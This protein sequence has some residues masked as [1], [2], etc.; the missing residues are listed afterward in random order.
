[1][2]F[3]GVGSTML[4]AFLPG[5]LVH[6]QIHDHQ[7]G[8]LVASLFLGSFAGTLSISEH[9]DRCL[10]RGSFAATLGCIGFAWA[11]HLA[12]GFVPCLFA[13][14]IM[15][16][17]M[18]QLMSSLNL[19]VGAAPAAT[20][21]HQ[22]ANLS[23]A[24]CVGA[25]LSPCL[26]TVLLKSVS[27]PL[28]LGLFAPMFLLP[29]W[30]LP[31]NQFAPSHPSRIDWAAL[32]SDGVVL[33]P[34]VFLIYGGIEASLSAWMPAFATRYSGGPLAATQWILSLF[35]F[36]LIL[37]R[38]SIAALSLSRGRA[39]CCALLSSLRS[40]VWCGCF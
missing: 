13:L 8:M 1:M 9:L 5:L 30:A 28:R 18:G 3:T 17:G 6:W 32:F 15:G 21:A 33:G 14:L 7:G 25:M 39:G 24:W 37:G 23:A 2:A 11:T 29:V 40:Y 26:S 35:W 12:H 22:L 36:G 34:I 20:R 38:I 16:F 27:A 19:L 10:R 31:D 4:G